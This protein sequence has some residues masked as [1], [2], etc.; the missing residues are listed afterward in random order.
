MKIF[1][2]Q[3]SKE[4]HRDYTQ[5]FEYSICLNCRNRRNFFLIQATRPSLKSKDPWV[6]I[7]FYLEKSLSLVGIVPC[8]KSLHQWQN[9]GFHSTSNHGFHFPV[10][11]HANGNICHGRILAFFQKK[12]N[13]SFFLSTSYHGS[14][15]PVPR[16]ICRHYRNYL[17]SEL[18]AIG[19]QLG[20]V[21]DTL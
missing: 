3:W 18:D 14:S 15:F 2:I 7:R 5:W 6:Q 8:H 20:L 11:F 9:V 19:L 1:R 21:P 13:V 10:P 16:K 17:S 4:F 12:R